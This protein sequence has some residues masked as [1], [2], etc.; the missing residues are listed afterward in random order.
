M[1]KIHILGINGSPH[2]NGI[3]A[4]ILKSAL[5]Q[6]KREGSETILVHLKD[7]E[8]NFFHGNYNTKIPKEL[9]SIFRLLKNADGI[10][11]ATPVYWFNVSAL[12]KNFIDQLT[13]LELKNFDLEG[14]VAGF[15]STTE[16]DGGLKAILDMAGPLNQMGLLIP[17]HAM[18][19]YN[20][21]VA[22]KS[23][24][25]WME[26]DA[27]LLGRNMVKLA[28]MTK[29]GDEYCWDYNKLK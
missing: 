11:F 29:T 21:R 13:I 27:K 19:F 26:R 1:S 22:N 14:K 15:I 17:P 28:G 4:K 24:H 6:S 10:I 5:S 20:K 3:C 23:E 25:K 18:V 9:A 12:M 16:E 2:K 7:Y 8:K